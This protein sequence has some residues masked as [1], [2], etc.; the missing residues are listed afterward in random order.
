[1]YSLLTLL[2]YYLYNKNEAYFG[3]EKRQK[4]KGSEIHSEMK[5]LKTFSLG[6][7]CILI[8]IKPEKKED[9]RDTSNHHGK[10]INQTSLVLDSHFSCRY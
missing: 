3:G 6:K 8:G 1:M 4:I 5:M 10:G 2:L 9:P 7:I